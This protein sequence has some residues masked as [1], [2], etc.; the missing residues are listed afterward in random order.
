MRK[1]TGKFYFMSLASGEKITRYIRDA[2]TMTDTVIRRV[3]QLS[4]GQPK[5]FIFTDRKGRPIGIVEFK[6]VDGEE[7][8]EKLD[9]DDNLELPDAVDEELSVQPPE[10]YQP[11]SLEYC[12]D[13]RKTVEH[14]V[15]LPHMQPTHP[16]KI[17]ADPIGVAEQAQVPVLYSIPGVGRSTRVKVQT[18]QPCTP[19][20][21]GKNYVMSQVD[22]KD[23]LHP[24]ANL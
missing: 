11:P 10:M 13:T 17:V 8:Q 1:F 16:P 6:G 14:H 20:M 9:E 12:P 18:Q 2:I 22:E 15:E 23:V 24:D 3:N 19:S 7:S 4:R 5:R 21:T